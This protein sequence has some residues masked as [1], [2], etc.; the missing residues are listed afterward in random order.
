M[1]VHKFTIPG[2]LDGMNT[3]I[4]AN[5]KNP[6]IGAKEKRKQQDIVIKAIR[7]HRLKGVRNYPVSIKIDWYE[8][9]N[10]RD[11]DNISAAKKFIFDALQETD[12]LKNDGF[13]EIKALRDDFHIDKLK[14]RIEV[15]ITESEA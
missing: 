5:R 10:R 4:A 6:Y 8:K 7:F 11:P 12:V 1:K 14:P 15:T 9:N 13:K 3:L 2:R